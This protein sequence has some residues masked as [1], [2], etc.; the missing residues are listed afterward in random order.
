MKILL[1]LHIV[2]ATIA[3]IFCTD[4]EKNNDSDNEVN[5]IL[6]REKR[7]AQN[8]RYRAVDAAT[9]KFRL[10]MQRRYTSQ[11]GKLIYTPNT[12]GA[13]DGGT[14]G[15]M[16]GKAVNNKVSIILFI[17]SIIVVASLYI[18]Y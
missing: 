12:Y 3:I 9:Q 16:Y 14:A 4:T 11:R 10:R 1:T 13:K 17:T 15:A 6:F 5:D 18:L 8:F 2:F 7:S